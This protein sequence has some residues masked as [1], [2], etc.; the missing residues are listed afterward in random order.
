MCGENINDTR[1]AFHWKLFTFNGKSGIEKF[2]RDNE[3]ANA[4]NVFSVTN[5]TTVTMSL[6]EEY[7]LPFTQ[8]DDEGQ[9]AKTVFL[10]SQIMKI[11]VE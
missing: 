8:H 7:H 1:D 4:A 3:I 11:S 9:N 6:G 2:R 5:K 10:F